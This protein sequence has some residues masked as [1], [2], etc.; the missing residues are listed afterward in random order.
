MDKPN[1]VTGSAKGITFTVDAL[2]ALALLLVS[3]T[4]ILGFLSTPS[5][6]KPFGAD[7]AADS[8][9]AIRTLKLSDVSGNPKYPY[10]NLVLSQN[11]TN[12][13]FNSSLAETIAELHVAGSATGN[14]TLTGLAAN[15]SREAVGLAVPPG[16]GVNVQITS[17]TQSGMDCIYSRAGS[18]TL[19]NST[20]SASVARHFVYYNN[21]TRELR[22]VVYQ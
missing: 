3:V 15:V 10:S 7:L 1:P 14:Q 11:L 12:A 16:F 9:D 8:I 4:L 5:A 18:C 21:A 22:I 2:I 6:Y 17:S 13:T 20:L 19:G